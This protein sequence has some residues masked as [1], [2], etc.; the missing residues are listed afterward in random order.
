MNEQAIYIIEGM[1]SLLILLVLVVI[2]QLNHLAHTLKLKTITDI[3]NLITD[4]T[5]HIMATFETLQNSVTE[6]NTAVTNAVNL[7]NSTSG[8]I[9]SEQA[10]TINNGII[11]ATTA[12]NNAV[13]PQP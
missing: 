8:A 12:L 10:D 3:I 5:K 1:L 13:T 11:A 6:L 4:K 2:G 7:I 9:T